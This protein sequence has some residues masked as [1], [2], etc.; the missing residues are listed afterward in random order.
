M[1]AKEK[2][3]H[4]IPLASIPFAPFHQ[5]RNGCPVECSLRHRFVRSKRKLFA[6]VRIKESNDVEKDAILTGYVWGSEG[7]GN[8]LIFFLTQ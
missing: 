4:F 3:S 2:L 1:D 5:G 8:L 6:L 7:G